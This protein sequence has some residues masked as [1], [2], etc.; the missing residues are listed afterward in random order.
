MIYKFTIPGRLP[1]M[2]EIVSASKSHYMQYATMKKDNTNLVSM[3][4]KSSVKRQLDKIDIEINWICKNRRMDK[5]NIIAGT[6]FILDGLVNA[7]IIKNDGW[8][9]IGDINHKFDVDK[10]DPRIEVKLKEI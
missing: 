3:I 4:A 5:D 9:E 8:S 10:K 7:G 6:K 1:S 2:N